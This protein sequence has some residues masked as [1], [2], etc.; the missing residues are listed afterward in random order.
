MR[1]TSR[2]IFKFIMEQ[3]PLKD[4]TLDASKMKE[5]TD[6]TVS[7][8]CKVKEISNGDL[9]RI[10]LDRDR[11]SHLHFSK[12][13][14]ESIDNLPSSVT[15]I[16]FACD[17]VFDQPVDHL[18]S[19]LTQL[20]FGRAFNHDVDHLPYSLLKLEFGYKFNR[21][22]DNLPFKLERLIFGNDFNKPVRLLPY[23]LRYIFFGWD[24]EQ[25]RP[26]KHRGVEIH[27]HKDDVYKGM[28]A[29]Q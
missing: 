26:Y 1:A 16:I 9:A 7:Q 6:R 10:T 22:V 23:S 29:L 20:T 3:D 17:S 19:S 18:P 11:T 13:F 4:M 25:E 28:H 27:Y 5:P 14:N 12:T 21:K 15:T 24:F 2:D 8:W